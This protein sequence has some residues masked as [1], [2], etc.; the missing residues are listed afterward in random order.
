MFI[1]NLYVAVIIKWCFYKAIGIVLGLDMLTACDEIML[2]DYPI[3]PFNIPV[4]LVID[5]SSEPPEEMLQKL[6]NTLSNGF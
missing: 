6:K 5:K 1:A 4:F 2:Y 3:N